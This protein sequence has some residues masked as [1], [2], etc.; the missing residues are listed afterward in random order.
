M[1]HAAID[2]GASLILGH[3]P[4]ILQGIERYNDGLVLYSLGNF[5]FGSFSPSAKT[6]ALA[7]VSLCREG[8][9]GF[10][11]VPLNVDNFQV[12]FRPR[13]VQGSA[14]MD[15]LRE[16]QSMS[17]PLGMTLHWRQGAII[18]APDSGPEAGIQQGE[19]L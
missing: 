16:L 4:H 17:A 11:L 5:A 19:T 7:Q 3:H 8:V 1:A 9:P 10:R 12:Y 6:S 18:E 14:A 13:P 2:A 15:I